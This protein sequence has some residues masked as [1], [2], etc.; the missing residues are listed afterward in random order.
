MPCR[1]D[2][3]TFTEDQRDAVCKGE[4]CPRCGKTGAQF[5]TEFKGGVLCY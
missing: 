2:E 1:P 3:W 5:L 4:L